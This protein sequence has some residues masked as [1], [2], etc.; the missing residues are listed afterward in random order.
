MIIQIF[1]YLALTVFCL[2][3]HFQT[4]ALIEVGFEELNPIVLW[5]IGEDQNWDRLLIYKVGSLSLLGL[6]LILNFHLKAEKNGTIHKHTK[7]K[8]LN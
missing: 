8:R 7:N 3:D 2:I 4:V 5:I 6:L 1:L